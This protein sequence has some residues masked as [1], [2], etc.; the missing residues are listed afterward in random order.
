MNV[1]THP[2]GLMIA[3]ERRALR[4]G[5]LLLVLL[6][7]NGSAWGEKSTLPPAEYLGHYTIQPPQ[8]ELDYHFI[9]ISEAFSEPLDSLEPS[10]SVGQLPLMSELWHSTAS[11]RFV[12]KWLGIEKN[13]AL[14]DP[15]CKF[16]Y[17]LNDFRYTENSVN[18]AH[19]WSE[20]YGP[21]GIRVINDGVED[22]NPLGFMLGDPLQQFVKKGSIAAFKPDG[23]A[24]RL[25]NDLGHCLA[26]DCGQWYAKATSGACVTCGKGKIGKLAKGTLL[27]PANYRISRFRTGRFFFD[28][29][30]IEEWIHLLG[31]QSPPLNAVGGSEWEEKVTPWIVAEPMPS[32]VCHYRILGEE[33]LESA[34]V[35]RIEYSIKTPPMNMKLAGVNT[36][37]IDWTFERKGLLWLDQ[38][39]RLPRRH[40]LEDKS[41]WQEKVVL[42]VHG[43]SNKAMQ[44]QHNLSIKSSFYR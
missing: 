30:K 24:W 5:L 28:D 11:G 41:S 42:K 3:L 8:T 40:Q 14:D 7:L 29:L 21:E 22:P 36:P 27:Y 12:L 4:P 9:I 44:V 19:A 10:T 23:R 32:L 25:D 1:P 38:M 2:D 16:S 31:G 13:G 18:Q 43:N 15:I 39:D 6:F 17:D 37:V 35:W 34:K 33:E 20:S 26:K